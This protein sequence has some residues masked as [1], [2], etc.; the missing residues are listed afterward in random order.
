MTGAD[1]TATCRDSILSLCR[2]AGVGFFFCTVD[3]WVLFFLT[4]VLSAA[5]EYGIVAPSL[6]GQLS[7]S[8]CLFN[9]KDNWKEGHSG[10]GRLL[11]PL[12]STA[13][14]FHERSSV[15][16]GAEC[17]VSFLAQACWD[18]RHSPRMPLIAPVHQDRLC[19]IVVPHGKPLVQEMPLSRVQY[20]PPQGSIRMGAP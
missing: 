17:G 13:F 12:L 15:S 1:L 16:V 14:H 3:R 20:P 4:V 19:K 18:P 9:K 2:S 10:C 11:S 8:N 5:D 6:F 7:G